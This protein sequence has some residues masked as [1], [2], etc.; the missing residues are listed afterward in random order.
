M[1]IYLGVTARD[2]PQA[3]ATGRRFAHVAYRIGEQSTLL[4]R[5]LP[6]QT[7]GGLLS[8]SDTNAPEILHPEELC[9]EILR[10]CVRRGYNGAVLD[11]ES[12]PRED[13]RNF[14]GTLGRLLHQNGRVVYVPGVYGKDVPEAVRLICTAVSGGNFRDYLRG[15][16][17]RAG[18]VRRVALDAERLRMDFQLPSPDGEGTALDAQ[19]FN[20]LCKDRSIYFS[21]DLCARYFTCMRNGE[22]HFILFDDADTLNRKLKTG[23]SMG[24]ETAFLMWPEIE[25]IADSLHLK[26]F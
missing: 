8:L 12:P 11:F 2:Y 21:P 10:E 3:S 22:A 26:E 4:R 5:N 6:V 7:R 25:D 14:A 1:R 16:I 24:I 23:E 15:E 17:E 13:L 20:A 18:D 9:A 19:T